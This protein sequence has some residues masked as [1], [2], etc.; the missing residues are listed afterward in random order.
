MQDHK[1]PTLRTG[2]VL[3]TALALGA[4]DESK[5]GG[6]TV[7][8]KNEAASCTLDINGLGGTEWLFLKAN[9]DKTEVPDPTIRVKFVSEGGKTIAKYNVGSNT[10]MYDY[11]CTLKGEELTCKEDPKVKDWCQ[12]LEAGGAA[13]S[14]ETLRGIDPDITDEQV[15]KGMADAEEVMKKY[16][17]TPDW[18]KFKFQNNNLGNKLQ[19]L[20]YVKVDKRN[21]RLRVIDNYMTIYN[22][23]RKEDSNPA[24]TNAFVKNELGE[25]S[26]LNCKDVSSIAATSESADYPAKP[27]QFPHT[28]RQPVGKPIQFW[29]LHQDILKPE[30][31]CTF[32]GDWWLN[33]KSIKKGDAPA[34]VGGKLHWGYSHTFDGP[35]QSA[36]GDVLMLDYTKTCPGKEDFN[37]VTCAAILVQ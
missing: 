10:A 35:T 37:L 33:G 21:C 27:E 13:C 6:F 3:L 26:W 19:G 17:N 15:T 5:K 12:A 23:V 31:G 9:P 14:P 22:G 2:L 36:S 32:K 4:C 11:N 20:L 34:D 8:E 1:Q 28:A 7:G 25:F 29:M 30:A 24:G 18:E 16:R